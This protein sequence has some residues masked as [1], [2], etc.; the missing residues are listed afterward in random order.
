MQ[1]S[2]CVSL[3]LGNELTELPKV[4]NN[5]EKNKPYTIHSI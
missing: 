3:V 5:S 4:C 1:V 2:A